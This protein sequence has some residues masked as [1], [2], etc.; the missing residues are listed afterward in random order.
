MM[1]IL[2]KLASALG[3]NDEAPN[4]ILAKEIA[5][6]R[7][8]KAVRELVINLSNTDKAIQS[9]CIKV[10]YEVGALKPD[11]IADYVDD[12]VMLLEGRNNRLIWGAMTAL[13]AIADRRAADIW[14]HIDA[15]IEATE[16]GSVITQDWGIRVLAAVS[17]SDKSREK[18]ILPF[19]TAFL[20]KCPPKDLPRH[21]ASVMVAV[22][23]GNR[24]E[25]GSILEARR[26]SLKPAQARRLD[27][28]I[29]K[30][31]R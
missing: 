13:G 30:L 23:G 9:D 25:I 26:T 5:E 6:A 18:H 29:R 28:I 16:H 17:A 12:F 20:Q 11:L 15:I 31:K 27:Q 21:A 7:D 19:L 4:Q 22:N 14:E 3:R 24:A 2:N 8:K 1:S 10:L